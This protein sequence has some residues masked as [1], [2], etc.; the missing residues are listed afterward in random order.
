ME[1]EIAGWI[2]VAARFVHVLAAIMWIG[3]SLLF[4]WMEI[5]LLP[6][7]SNEAG[8]GKE[9]PVLG[10]LDMLHGG[11]V[12]HL[13]KRILDPKA[14]PVPLHWF[15]WQ[16]YTTWISGAVLMVSV[17]YIHGGTALLDA[18]K[19]SITGG[20]AIAMSVGGI[21]VGWLIYD[22]LWRSKLKNLPLV[23]IPT[24]LVLLLGAAWFFDQFF[25]GRTVYLQIGAMMGTFMSAN[26]F[27]HIIRNQKKYM[28]SI[29]SG[30]PHNPDY[31]KAAKTRSLH[32]HYMTY[33]VLFTMLSAH[34]PQ[35]TS[36]TWSVPI[37]AVLVVTLMYG[38]FLLNSRNQ[39]PNWL[40]SLFG[41]LIL[42]G[43]VIAV[44]IAWPEDRVPM[45]VK[46]A[47]SGAAVTESVID[48][49]VKAG[50]K[51]FISQTCA[52]CH[53]GG[54]SQL[55]PSLN[56]IYNKTVILA[57]NTR[58]VANEAYLRSSILNPQEQIV[59]GYP[60][61]MPSFAHLQ[62]EQVDQL[63]AYIKSLK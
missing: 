61:A 21:V 14:I 52:T 48:P 3:N 35:L 31:G 63:V 53:Q 19:S 43:I 24:S 7:K 26:V 54:S 1:S 16:S 23:A 45:P 25:N 8:E 22:S 12:F 42:A 20:V 33:P 59:K 18:T 2:S 17:F 55:G 60:A 49:S 13:Q 36:A 32:N 51:L 10:Y 50:A 27:F 39:N 37:L 30:H 38:K 40:V 57:D 28:A 4:T 9:N 44:M 15:M 29:E 58:V 56:G 11:G 5:N 46:T 47:S 41:S 62:P 34:F 6:P